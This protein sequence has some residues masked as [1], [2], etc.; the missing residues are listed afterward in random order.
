MAGPLVPGTV[1]AYIAEPSPR[2]TAELR[3]RTGCISLPNSPTGTIA[4]REKVGVPWLGL[5][6]LPCSPKA[7]LSSPMA[8]SCP[9]DR[10]RTGKSRAKSQGLALVGGLPSSRLP[11]EAGDVGPFLCAGGGWGAKE[12]RAGLKAPFLSSR[13]RMMARECLV[14]SWIKVRTGGGGEDE[15]S[16]PLLGCGGFMASPPSP[17]TWPGQT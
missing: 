6:P 15:R 12:D 8:V 3:V 2:H 7:T 1:C 13:D 9:A 16:N 4:G 10:Q 14:H 11:A 5:A 17:W